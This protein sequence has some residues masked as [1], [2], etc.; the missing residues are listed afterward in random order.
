M[1]VV[2]DSV[3][4][5]GGAVT[6]V[7]TE[8]L[9][10]AEVAHASLTELEVTPDMHA[11]KARMSEL[12]DGVVVLPGGF[13]TF[14]EAFEILTWN[15]LG[16]TSAPVVFLDV[17]GFYTSLFDFIGVVVDAGFMKPDHGALAQRATDPDD[18]VRLATAPSPA[19]TP[20]WIG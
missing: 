3:M 15:Q 13:G 8:Q 7:M 19:V 12:A 1:G 6:G 4:A 20:K 11:R 10:A 16:L 17:A 9:V 5:G 14:E 2:A 18:A